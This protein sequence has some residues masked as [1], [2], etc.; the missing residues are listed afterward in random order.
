MRVPQIRMAFAAAALAV[1]AAAGCGGGND[2]YD[3]AAGQLSGKIGGKAWVLG[4][5]ETDAFLSSAQALAVSFLPDGFTACA[6]VAPDA[7]SVLMD[8]PTAAGEYDLSLT[9]NAT[10]YVAATAHNLVATR[11][12][13]VVDAVGST[14]TG[15]VHIAYNADNEVSGRFSITVCP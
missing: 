5:G 7:D 3:I 2:G 6:G 12:R 14:V 15:G 4:A 8:V 13:L 1:V 9:R 10:F 11:G